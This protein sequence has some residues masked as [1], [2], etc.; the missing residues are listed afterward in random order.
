VYDHCLEALNLAF[1]YCQGRVPSVPNS[2]V[3]RYIT[4]V[5]TCA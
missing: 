1:V 4:F 2:I 3:R 5:T